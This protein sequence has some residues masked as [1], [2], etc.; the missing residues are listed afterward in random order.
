MTVTLLKS[1]EMGAVER[2]AASKLL[3]EAF[4]RSIF[5][6]NTING[7]FNEFQPEV[8]NV[9]LIRQGA[10]IAG[11][12]IAA[13]RISML[14]GQPTPLLTVGPL[15]IHPRFQGLGLGR[16]LMSGLDILALT[17]GARG[18]YLQGIPD[19][20]GRFGYFPVL[21]RSKAV[22]PVSA[23]P[24]VP[25][26]SRRPMARQDR[27]AM[28]ELF[29][30]QRSLNSFA[31]SRTVH[32]WQWLTVHAVETYYFYQ[33]QVVELRGRIVGYFTS[34]PEL[35][36][37]IREAIVE[38]TV[39]CAAAFLAAVAQHASGA[40]IDEVE[41][42][43][44]PDSLLHEYL[45]RYAS[46]Q[47]TQY[48]HHDGGQVLRILHPAEEFMAAL[49]SLGVAAFDATV[50]DGLVTARAGVSG[51]SVS[52]ALEELPSWLSGYRKNCLQI[53]HF[54]PGHADALR[55]TSWGV[56]FVYQGDN[57]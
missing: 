36:G 40:L 14:G 26:V 1:S 9:V 37:R 5:S 20:Y 8:Q 32:D 31:S 13:K 27:T 18:L 35:P 38:Q 22:V 10:S 6:R 16:E 48:F 7:F 21:A 30:I 41:I 43:M 46:G 29:E 53:E 34:D 4:G 44:P 51:G 23:L 19:F 49:I 50:A 55:Q 56:P 54:P 15:A 28:A 24:S 42:M 2:E 45:S 25:G 17:V 52:I 33:P 12:A 39:E 57:F 47:F 11:L 3:D